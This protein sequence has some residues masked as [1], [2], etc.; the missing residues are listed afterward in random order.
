M[1]LSA[2]STTSVPSLLGGLRVRTAIAPPGGVCVSGRVR[3]EVRDRLDVSFEDEGEQSL[4]NIARPV[5]VYR[6]VTE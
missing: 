1:P 4:K 5:R 2:I 3:D 6:V